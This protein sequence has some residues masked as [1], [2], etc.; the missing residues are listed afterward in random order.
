M[1][2]FPSVEKMS[3]STSCFRHVLLVRYPPAAAP[4]LVRFGE[5]GPDVVVCVAL[6]DP[7][8]RAPPAAD[9]QY[10]EIYQ[11]VG[12]SCH[13]MQTPEDVDPQRSPISTSPGGPFALRI[14]TAQPSITRDVSKTVINA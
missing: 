7:G 12:F 6:G 1:K 4:E 14:H 11:P 13:L 3:S 2:A 9:I 8:A 5:P 10:L